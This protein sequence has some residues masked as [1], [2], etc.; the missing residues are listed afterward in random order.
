MKYL[1]GLLLLPLALIPGARAADLSA[2]E[3][4]NA[5]TIQGHQQLD[6]G[7]AAAAYQ[8]WTKA[9]TI[10][11]LQQHQEGISG[12][13]VN[14]SLAH[15]QLG[16]F[17]NACV[18]LS[19]ALDIETQLC[20][21]NS[22]GSPSLPPFPEKPN[23][24]VQVLALQN[25]G[26]VLR[27]LGHLE[28]SEQILKRAISSATSLKADPQL[29]ASRLSLANTYTTRFQAARQQFQLS[30][31]A[32]LQGQNIKLAAKYAQLA[33][34]ELEELEDTP[35]T[36]QSRLNWLALYSELE[37]WVK[38]DRA[39]IFEINAIQDTLTPKRFGILQSLAIA[40]FSQLPPI[41]SLYAKLKLSK[42]LTQEKQP[43][44]GK[45]PLIIAFEQTQAA[46]EQANQLNNPRAQS[47]VY[48][49]FG[50]LYRQ[51]Q[52]TEQAIQAYKLAARYAQSHQAWDALYQWHSALAGIYQEQGQ[53]QNATVSYQSAIQALDQ[54]SWNFLP[55]S[56]DLQ[57]SFRE[58]VEPV[59][60]SYMKLLL[61]ANRPNLE[62]VSQV[63]QRLRLAELENF[64]RCGDID[65]VPL[66]QSQQQDQTVVQVI[67]LGNQTT[68]II[69]DHHYNVN[70][71]Q[72]QQIVDELTLILQDP[73]FYEIPRGQYLPLFQAL[74]KLLLEPALEENLIPPN[75]SIVFH[76]N[77]PLQNIPM[78][79]LHDGDHYLIKHNPIALSTGY[80]KASPT[81]RNDL[82]AIIG[83]V[84]ES[85]P[86]LQANNLNPLP[87][88]QEEIEAV[89][90]K[91]PRTELLLNQDFTYENLLSALERAT[92]P[93]LHLSTHGKFSSDPSQTFLLAWDNTLNVQDISSVLEAGNGSSNLNLLFLSAC[94]SAQGDPRSLL[95][96]AGLSA[97]SGASNTV[98]S[99]WLADASASV[100]LSQTFY[101]LLNDE[102]SMANALRKAQL[103]LLDSA[104]A[105]PYY[106][107][108]YVLVQL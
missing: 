19:V 9:L 89:Q 1:V 21:P 23:D 59:Y 27:E 30:G 64:L 56:S 108:N 11:R 97:Q 4:A 85:A 91:V 76:L 73:S 20:Q 54:V 77:G 61:Q 96:L 17:F 79:L 55:L 103:K 57:F 65:L 81:T 69:G 14:Q 104:Y 49:K 29:Q 7:N 46:L 107:A 16:Q 10:Y 102:E 40:D 99:L 95:G 63:N 24:L 82:A 35:Y 34:D 84:S 83:G 58:K 100:V 41:E 44:A 74:H 48:G 3:Q 88:V 25:F 45:A 50:S 68:V 70:H 31:E 2:I 5:L 78:A 72:L 13:L 94:Q 32:G 36:I 71:S 62:Q 93:I 8:S 98:A 38:Q 86:S 12:S 106:W 26:S 42:F 101:A 92:T 18:K 37:Q 52:Q 87:E 33:I 47:F 66:A 28:P 105:H 39:G 60:Q 43:I 22:S 75:T 53:T 90:A 15:Q 67:D 6:D 80:V 51:N